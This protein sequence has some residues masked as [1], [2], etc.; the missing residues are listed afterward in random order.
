MRLGA[1]FAV[2]EINANGGLL[3]QKL[4]LIM[5]NDQ[6]EPKY[7]Q[8]AA[9]K[10]IGEDAA[11][12][13][14]H[15]CSH[16]SLPASEIYNEENII[17]ITPGSTAIKLTERGFN[18]VFRFVGRDD[19]QG[20]VAAKYILE[21]FQD[22]KVAIIHDKQAY[23]KGLADEVKKNLNEAGFNEV[24][25][26]TVTPGE[27]DYSALVTRLKSAKIDI[28]YYGGYHTEAAVITRQMRDQG[29]DTINY[30]W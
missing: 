8:Q 28:L 4:R 24:I 2:E 16:T 25:Y 18:N 15:F 5:Q 13:I 26:D 29:L 9:N 11:V 7:A 14:G 3:G 17:M 23:S 12:V 27:Q 10:L 30:V 6:C 21:N 1:S 20:F 22:K 19:E